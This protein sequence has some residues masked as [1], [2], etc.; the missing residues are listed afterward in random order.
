MFLRHAP[1]YAPKPRTFRPTPSL[2]PYC[3]DG[4][5]ANI[6]IPLLPGSGHEAYLHAIKQI[7]IPALK[8]FEPELIIAPFFLAPVRRQAQ[9]AFDASPR[10]W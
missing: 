10:R 7:V 9:Q 6:D 8:R 5:G 1:G 4:L 3:G 2:Q